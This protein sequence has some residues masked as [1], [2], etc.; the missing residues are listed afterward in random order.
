MRISK[1]AR[2]AGNIVLQIT[3][4]IDMTF[5][6]LIYFL[7]TL[8]VATQ[9]GLLKTETPS[10]QGAVAE[11]E[12][13]LEEEEAYIRIVRAGRTVGLFFREWPVAG[14]SDLARQLRELPP[15][16]PVFV[17][18][19]PDVAYRDVV[20]VHNLC[21]KTGHRDVVFTLPPA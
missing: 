7:L 16:T 19:A 5:L 18:A 11:R 2:P 1:R 12:E 15:E 8:S 14:Y 3:P 10:G 6:L 21:L 9:E 17:D 20:R 13:S 4:M